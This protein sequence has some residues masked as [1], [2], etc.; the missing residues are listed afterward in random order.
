MA[1][2]DPGITPA[3]KQAINDMTRKPGVFNDFDADQ[4]KTPK[5]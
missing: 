3:L 2:K 1:K 5:K 4:N